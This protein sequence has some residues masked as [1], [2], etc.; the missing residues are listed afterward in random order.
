MTVGS[1]ENLNG[2]EASIQQQ[3][4]QLSSSVTKR[5]MDLAKQITSGI[6]QD[7]EKARGNL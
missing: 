6:K 3:Y 4:T 5:T 1:Q 2:Y 7:S